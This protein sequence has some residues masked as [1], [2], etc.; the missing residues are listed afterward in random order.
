MF[1]HRLKAKQETRQKQSKKIT[2]NKTNIET[3]RQKHTPWK[4][5]KTT[6]EKEPAKNESNLGLKKGML[7]KFVSKKQANIRKGKGKKKKIKET[8][9]NNVFEKGV[10]GQKAKKKWNFEREDKKENQKR[11]QN[12]K[13]R[14]IL[15]TGLS[16]E[17]NKKNL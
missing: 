17:Q 6:A 7:G 1:F 12:R 15:K 8:Q 4:Q 14:R 10:D 5:K 11:K 3:E 13:K 16:G 2:K 9:N